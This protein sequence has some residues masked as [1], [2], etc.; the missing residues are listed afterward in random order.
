MYAAKAAGRNTWREHHVDLLPNSRKAQWLVWSERLNDAFERNLFEVYVQG[1]FHAQTSAIDHYEA[2]VRLPDPAQPGNFYPV[3]ELIMYAEDSGKIVALDRLMLTRSIDHLARHPAHPP[4]AVNIST[5][6]LVDTSL[7]DFIEGCLS[8]AQVQPGR[9][10][11]E[12]TETAA[13]T[14][15][16]QAI[17]TVQKVQRLGCKVGLDDFGSGFTSF[18]YLR[19]LKVDYIKMDG[20]FVRGLANDRECQIL[21]QAVVDIAHASGRRVVAEWVEDESLLSL[22]RTYGVDL[23]QGYHFGQPRPL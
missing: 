4:I 18:T 19:D 6:T 2:L 7:T 13:L 17:Q 16:E 9:L 20:S 3:G 14:N 22:V 1:I 11:L 8:Q 23:V 15:I 5:R 21:L 12:L 10:H